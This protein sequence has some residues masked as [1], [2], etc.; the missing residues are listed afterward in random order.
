[1]GPRNV[2]N[3]SYVTNPDVKFQ[4]TGVTG[5]APQSP[6]QAASEGYTLNSTN[7]SNPNMSTGHTYNQSTTDPA[8]GQPYT[9]GG[10]GGQTYTGGAYNGGG[11]AYDG[12]AQETATGDSAA[13]CG[14]TAGK[15]VHGVF[16]GI[17]GVGEVI[18]GN[19]MSAVDRALG[20]QE[21]AAKN[22]AIAEAGRQEMRGF[23]TGSNPN[24]GPRY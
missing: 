11:Q 14:G 4:Q 13:T 6:I 17:H 7:Q 20:N 18:R 2:M 24:S 1:M 8:G 9:G 21:G 22:T 23:S 10:G 19:V 15:N 3:E 16:K 5:G 12:P